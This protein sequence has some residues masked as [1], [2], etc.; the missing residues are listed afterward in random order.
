MSIGIVADCSN[1]HDVESTWTCGYA[2]I[3]VMDNIDPP[4]PLGADL[5]SEW[6]LNPDVTF[7]NHGSFGA[8]PRC[9]LDEH[10]NWRLRIETDPVETLARRGQQLLAE[11][12]RQMGAWLGM[13]ADDFGF[14]TNATE[15]VNAVLRSLKWSPGDELLTT[16]HVYNA[17]R[18]AMKYSAAMW[19]ATYREIDIPLPV[20]SPEQVADRVLAGL[21]A[22]TRLLV[23]DHITSPTALVFPVEPILEGCARRGVDVLIDGAHAPG[24]VPLDIPRL[25]AAYY[26]GNLHKWACAPKGSGFLWVRK[27]RQK[28]IHPLVISHHL[29]EGFTREFG[30]QGT[31]DL[32][33]WLAIPRALEFMSRFGWQRVM[34][35]NQKMAVWVQRLLCDQWK[36]RPISALDGRMLGSMATLPLPAPLEGIDEAKASEL[37]QRLY[38]EH[39]IEAP[40]MRWG[41]RAFVRPCCQIYNEPRDYQHLADAILRLV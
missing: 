30:W 23:I 8:V 31:R 14:V 13:S 40:I 41:G 36:V 5:K 28:D 17:V 1:I 29:G 12:K 19:G 32:A 7:L 33:A 18:Q 4:A 38:D 26:A 2:L 20:E 3:P 16:T 15:G 35:H 37:Q 34:H 11:T 27:D 21:S 39:R 24:M 10:T 6:L 25:S 9:V 22:R